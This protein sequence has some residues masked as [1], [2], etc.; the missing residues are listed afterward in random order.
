MIAWCRTGPPGASVV[1]LESFE[2]SPIGERGF[3][4]TG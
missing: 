2:R 4:I 3:R 1:G